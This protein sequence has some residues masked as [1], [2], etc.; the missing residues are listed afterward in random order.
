MDNAS[1]SEPPIP[2]ALVVAGSDSG[3]GAGIRSNLKTC[4]DHGVYLTW[5]VT[6]VTVQ[7]ALGVH[8]IH[9]IPVGVVQAHSI[10]A[11][12]RSSIPRHGA[13][14]FRHEFA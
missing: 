2:V 13:R 12:A 6:A 4:H 1:G 9:S 8:Q 11:R 7:D 14:Q 10:G 3:S 5:A